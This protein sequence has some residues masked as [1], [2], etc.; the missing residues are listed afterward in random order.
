MCVCVCARARV[1]RHV[2]LCDPIDCSP[3]DSSVHEI[4]QARSLKWIAIL[5]QGI[6]PTQES[7][8]RLLYLLHWQL[9]LYHCA[10]WE[11]LYIQSNTI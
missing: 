4:L 6:F 10:T 5:L 1:L 9:I 11:A 3:P 2:R 7:N 8:P